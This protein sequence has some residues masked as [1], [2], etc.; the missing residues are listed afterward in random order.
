[1]L[2]RVEEGLVATSF[3]KNMGLYGERTGSLQIVAGTADAAEAALS[4]AKQLIRTL[5]SNPPKHGAALAAKILGDAALRAEWLDELRAMQRRIAGNREKL[6]AGL[7]ARVPGADFGHIL[8]QKGMFSYSGLD[9]G[10]V[11]WLREEKGIYMVKGGRIN[12]AGLLDRQVDYVCDSIA[13]CLALG[14]A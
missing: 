13:A 2:D 4:H 11:R 12:V 9:E 5:Y 8:R 14:N 6:V 10:Q 7:A 3:S 1:M